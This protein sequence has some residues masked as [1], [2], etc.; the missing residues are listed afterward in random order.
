MS[1]VS[2]QIVE[3][4]AE[5]QLLAAG[6]AVA[7][8]SHVDDAGERPRP[9]AVILGKRA[10][11]AIRRLNPHLPADQA[12]LVVAALEHECRKMAE[13]RDCLLPKLLSGEVR[14]GEAERGAAEEVA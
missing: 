10:S 4:A 11:T 8:G 3:D 2:E 14:V 12:D 6:A 7:R 5:Q 13:V 9:E 1:A